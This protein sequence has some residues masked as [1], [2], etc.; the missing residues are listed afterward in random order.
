MKYYEIKD[1]GHFA[2]YG[3][4]VLNEPGYHR[5]SIEERNRL[6]TENPDTAWHA[7]CSTGIQAKFFT[8]SRQINVKVHLLMPTNM[9]NMCAIGQSGVDLYYLNKKTHEF[10]LLDVSRFDQKATEYEVSIGNF[11]NHQMTEYILNLPLYMGA[12]EVSVGLDDDATV[13]PSCFDN[14]KR[15]AVYGTSIVQGG[16]VSRPG[17]LLTNL[18]SR[19]RNQEFLNFGFSGSAMAEPAM[20][21]FIGSRPNLEMLVIDVEANAGTTLLLQERLPHFMK[22][23]RQYYP[24]LPVLIVSRT[25]M[26]IDHY[27]DS[28]IHLRE[29]YLKWLAQFVRK[30]RKQGENLFFMN[31]YSVFL[32]N[33]SEYTVDGIHPS[34]WGMMMLA[35]AYQRKIQ[36]CLQHQKNK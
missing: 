24:T 33:K 35:K 19:W 3:S 8:D 29:H 11:S 9:N 13:T 5:L 36:S 10:C 22:E 15:V 17:M 14:P 34:D 16:C 1:Q 21:D 32:N 28:R 20:A 31:G 12:L 4:D 2:L 23:F 18:L 27:D 25:P 30:G 6:K 7:L 26:S